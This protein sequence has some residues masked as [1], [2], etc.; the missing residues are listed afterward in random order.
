M[1]ETPPDKPLSRAERLAQ[2]TE[3]ITAR[4]DA[5]IEREDVAFRRLHEAC[6]QTTEQIDATIGKSR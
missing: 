6:G 2:D 5:D 3:S 4:L 1:T